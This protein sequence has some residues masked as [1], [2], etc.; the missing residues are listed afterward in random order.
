MPALYAENIKRT[1]FCSLSSYHQALAYTV[2]AGLEQSYAAKMPSIRTSTP[3]HA[4]AWL[5]KLLASATTR[6][7]LNPRV[8]VGNIKLDH[9]FWGR[10]EDMEAA[11]VQ[12]PVYLINATQP[13]SDMAGAAAAA[14]ASASLVGLPSRTSASLAVSASPDTCICFHLPAWACTHVGNCVVC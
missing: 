2:Q 5:S 13:G 11:G 6:S 8:Q 10:P 7:W 1:P 9:D 12:R 3:A 14:L 4:L